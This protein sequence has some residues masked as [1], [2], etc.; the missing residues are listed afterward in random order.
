MSNTIQSK[1]LA[2]T[3]LS[4]SD[5]LAIVQG[6]VLKQT[7]VGDLPD[8]T[9]II[10]NSNGTAVRFPSGIQLCFE[11]LLY[12]AGSDVA[13]FRST[14]D[15]P[16][17]FL[18]SAPATVAHVVRVFK[19]GSGDGSA[20]VTGDTSGTPIAGVS[21]TQLALKFVRTSGFMQTIDASVFALGVWK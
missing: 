18:S 16:A 10:N 4:T 13:T 17:S 19:S 3:P 7:T 11:R 20:F 12:D 14:W 2:T 15:F 9:S 6:G 21:T 8:G 1:T 5:I